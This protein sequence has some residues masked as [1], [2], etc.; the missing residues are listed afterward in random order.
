MASLQ[1]I[2]AAQLCVDFGVVVLIWLVQLVIYPSFLYYSKSDL[3]RWHTR[4]TSAV[5]VVVLP[6]MLS[7][8]FLSI[9]MA[10]RQYD[11]GSVLHLALVL[12]VWLI[13]FV[14][15]VPLHGKV[16]D[17]EDPQPI[18]KALIQI[19]WYRTIG[20]TLA[21]GISAVTFIL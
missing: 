19:N 20:W 14:R 7:Q 5:T 3:Q 9:F 1:Y 17:T 16:E 12:A 8:L 13:T 11:I 6:L 18:A 10:Y 15:A 21:F 4:Y 2:V